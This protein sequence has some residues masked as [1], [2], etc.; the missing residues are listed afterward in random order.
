MY[1]AGTRQSITFT[2]MSTNSTFS[3]FDLSDK[4]VIITGSGYGLG[5]HMAIGLAEAG[6]RVVVCGRNSDKLGQTVSEIT[7]R[8]GN[9]T[10]IPF[11]A[12]NKT[13]CDQLVK[14][15]AERFGGLDV[16]VIN[17]G[18]VAVNPPEDTT[19]EQWSHVIEVNL[20]SCFY[21]AQ[22]AGQQ[23]IKQNRGGSIV[24]TSSNGS[25]VSFDGLSAYGASK[26]G[27]DQLCR[28]LAAEWG[29]YQIRVNTVNPG[30]TENPMG[31]RPGNTVT[32]E[33]EQEIKQ[34]TPLGR[35]GR[36]DEFV[37]PVLFLASDASS[38]VSGHILTVDGG[39]CAV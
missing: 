4:S 31:G 8:G 26:G 12:T 34:R 38:Y 21:C 5:R 24:I 20:T 33:L 32:P 29:K 39:Y 35:R 25:L 9:A 27:V 16:M 15:T 3:L 18:V 2:T 23:M 30:Y 28:Q 14:Q 10:A 13:E 11:D 1:Y 19:P 36:A 37:G 17:H 7:E 22:A 6:A